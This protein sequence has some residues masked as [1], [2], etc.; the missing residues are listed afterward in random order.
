MWHRQFV[1][2]AQSFFWPGEAST[3]REGWSELVRGVDLREPTVT[4][5][6][7][8]TVHE[9]LSTHGIS[10]PGIAGLHV[11]NYPVFSGFDVKIH[12]HS[13]LSFSDIVSQENW[14]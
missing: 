6:K 3:I 5:C 11:H 10:I 13:W 9:S 2:A 1:E 12:F 8:I 14:S 7:T 4:L